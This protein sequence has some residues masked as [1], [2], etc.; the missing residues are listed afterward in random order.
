MCVHDLSSFPLTLS[1]QTTSDV[2]E[3]AV[4]SPPG[5]SVNPMADSW[6]YT[7]L[8][9]HKFSYMWTIE[10]F[11]FCKED[12]GEQ[13]KSHIFSSGTGPEDNLKWSVNL[14]CLEWCSENVYMYMLKNYRRNFF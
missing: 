6:C 12:I 4:N 1:I 11:S 2:M 9:V 13:L 7:H 14:V 10:N 3:R 8:R 5:P